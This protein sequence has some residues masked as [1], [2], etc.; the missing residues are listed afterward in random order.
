MM[1]KYK[2][3]DITIFV[4]KNYVLLTQIKFIQFLRRYIL[5]LGISNTYRK[6]YFILLRIMYLHFIII[7][8]FKITWLQF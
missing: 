2:I 8:F 6:Y 3:F 5:F 7:I 1:C 4:K